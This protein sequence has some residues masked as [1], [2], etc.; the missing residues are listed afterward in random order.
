MP[1]EKAVQDLVLDLTFL[2]VDPRCL[3]AEARRKNSAA[4]ILAAGRHSDHGLF[5][6]PQAITLIENRTDWGQ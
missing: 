2:Q 3:L 4:A 5:Q 1:H 6:H